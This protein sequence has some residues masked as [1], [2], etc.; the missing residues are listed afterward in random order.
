V[1]STSGGQRVPRRGMTN[2][3]CPMTNDQGRGPFVI[4]HSEFV[5]PPRRGA[6][7]P[8]LNEALSWKTALTMAKAMKPTKANT[9]RST[10]LAITPVKAD[11]W[12]EIL[13]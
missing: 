8:I 13:F 5:I 6:A 4:R 12:F 9:Q 10:P 2:D 3:Q 11:S 1:N 7:H